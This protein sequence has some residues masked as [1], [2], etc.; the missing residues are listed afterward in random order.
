[1]IRQIL[2]EYEGKVDD[3]T[4]DTDHDGYK[5]RLGEYVGNDSAE[6]LLKNI[7]EIWYKGGGKKKN[8]NKNGKKDR[9]KIVPWDD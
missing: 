5:D 8:K 3:G 9:P 2:K 4:D 1:M 7:K 6:Y